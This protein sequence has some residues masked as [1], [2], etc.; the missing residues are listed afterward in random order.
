MG[1]AENL[2]LKF[3]KKLGF[4]GIGG[5]GGFGGLGMGGGAGGF[6]VAQKDGDERHEGQ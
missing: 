5:F 2:R 1:I 4:G 3:P 6:S